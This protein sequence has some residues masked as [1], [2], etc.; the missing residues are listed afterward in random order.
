MR[1]WIW[2]D[3]IE[4]SEMELVAGEIKEYEKCL[5]KK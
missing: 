5:V 1:P 2:M 3:S 4:K